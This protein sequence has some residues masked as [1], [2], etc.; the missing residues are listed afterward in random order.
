MH[1]TLLLTASF[2]VF[3][4]ALA[5]QDEAALRSYFEG[6]TVIAKLAM[7]AAE[8]G[9]DVY[10][11]ARPPVDYPE[12]AK[13]LKKYGVAIQAGQP[14]LVTKLK[15]KGKLI[16]FQLDGGGYGT[17]G[18]PT[19]PTVAITSV[20]KTQRE[21]DLEAAVKKETDPAAKRR[22]EH[23]IDELRAQRERE[24]RRNRAIAASATERRRE[25]LQERRLQGGSRFN[26]RYPDGIPPEALQVEAVKS[27]LAEFVDFEPPAE[28]GPN[29]APPDSTPPPA[30]PVGPLALRKGLLADEVDQLLGPPFR[31]TNRKEGT[32]LVTTRTYDTKSGRVVAEFVE[33]VLIRYTITSR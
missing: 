16:E 33:D 19:D 2:Q 8:A 26:L 28:V 6:K 29:A 1:R 15:V 25:Y 11:A 3:A 7:P 17:S 23:E 27:A 21:K 13:R 32:L 14:A 10:P 20:P 4:V 31:R 24:D 18:D 12:H 9:V 30:E 22:M 5:A